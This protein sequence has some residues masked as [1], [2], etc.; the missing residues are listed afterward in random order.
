MYLSPFIPCQSESKVNPDSFREAKCS[1]LKES[2]DE[3]AKSD[4]EVMAASETASPSESHN[5]SEG[6]KKDPNVRRRELLVDSG[7]AEVCCFTL[8]CKDL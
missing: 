4:L 3:E 5:L 7:L 1:E 2:C 6:G 8:L